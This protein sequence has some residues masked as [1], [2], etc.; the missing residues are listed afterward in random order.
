MAVRN[1]NIINIYNLSHLI[2]LAATANNN[3]K[4]TNKTK[5]N[6]SES[7][8]PNIYNWDFNVDIK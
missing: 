8:F 3:M 4:S 5:S 6:I 1:N 2:D 7:D